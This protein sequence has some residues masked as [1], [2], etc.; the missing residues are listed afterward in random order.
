MIVDQVICGYL[1]NPEQLV[2][3]AETQQIPYMSSDIELSKVV[4]RQRAETWIEKKYRK[5][6]PTVITFPRRADLSDSFVEMIFATRQVFDVSH[7][8]TFKERSRDKEILENI[9]NVDP[10]I[11]AL[12][13]NAKFVTVPN[14][15]GSMML[16][17]EWPSRSSLFKDEPEVVEVSYGLH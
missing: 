14:P 4:L 13:D 5:L 16:P 10:S 2:K 1:V 9:M 17:G 3:F 8:Y 6:H 15:S 11:R 12:L 7:K